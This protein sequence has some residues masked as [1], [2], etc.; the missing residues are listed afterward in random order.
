M[1]AL[2]LTV[3]PVLSVEGLCFRYPER[4]LFKNWS[5]CIRPGLTLLL[6]GDGSGKTS[7]LRLLAG[8]LSADAGEL[9]VHSTRLRDDPAA[10]RQQVFWVDPRS[11]AFEQISPVAYFQSLHDIYPKFD[12]QRLGELSTGLSLT[13][14]MEKPMYMLSTGSKRKVWLAAAFASGAS[15]TLLDDPFAALDKPS[16]RFVRELLAGAARDPSRACL[17]AHYEAPGDVPLTAVIK[18]DI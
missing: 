15:V 18:L 11:E 1:K 10:Y 9:Q 7:L 12:K 6:G 8:A 4:E 16:I 3:Q 5:G 13:E 17:L 2:D 14:H